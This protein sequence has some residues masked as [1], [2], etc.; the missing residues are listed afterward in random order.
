MD[1]DPTPFATLLSVARWQRELV[2]PTLLEELSRKPDAPG[3]PASPEAADRLAARQVRAAA[4]LIGLDQARDVF[5]LLRNQ[6]D[7]RLRTYLINW[8][9]LLGVD[10]HRRP[11]SSR[12][13]I[14]RA[15]PSPGRGGRPWTRSCSTARPRYAGR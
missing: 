12:T 13:S 6:P 5:P 11:P 4:A 3:P 1:A 2:R 8:L 9:H 14:A 15:T 7:P 10:P